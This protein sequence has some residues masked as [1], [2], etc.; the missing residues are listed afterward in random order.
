MASAVVPAAFHKSS[1]FV[2]VCYN[3]LAYFV[4]NKFLLACQAHKRECLFT[5]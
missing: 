2:H 4:V 1:Y 5:L 3:F